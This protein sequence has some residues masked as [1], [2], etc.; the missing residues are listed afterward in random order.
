MRAEARVAGEAGAAGVECRPDGSSSGTQ[1]NTSPARR[2][3]SRPGPS[4]PRPP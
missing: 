3:R 1:T 2:W 4:Y